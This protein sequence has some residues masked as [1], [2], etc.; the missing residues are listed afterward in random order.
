VKPPF[1][2]EVPHPR[3]FE[4]DHCANCL[5]ELDL[6]VTGLYCSTWC[7]EVA[8]HVRYLR[9]VFRDG[10]SNDPDVQ[11][12]IHTKNAFLLVGGYRSLGRKL[13]PQ[14]RIAV[15]QRDGGNCQSCGRPGA[16]VDHIDGNSDELE[17][18]QLLCL[19]CHHGKTAKNLVPASDESRQHLLALMKTRVAPGEPQLLADDD[20]N[21]TGQWRGLQVER[22]NRFLNLLQDAGVPIRRNVSHATRVR[23]YFE[24]VTVADEGSD[25]PLDPE[26]KDFFGDVLR[27]SG[28]L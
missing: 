17:N 19:D 28:S 11:L 18:L 6:D 3:Y 16:E 23:A 7:Q 24:V 10:R 1:E 14:L 5:E 20:I 27:R 2:I 21:W 26:S 4:D 13:T 12:A 8:S 22:K 15:R 25:P 9:R